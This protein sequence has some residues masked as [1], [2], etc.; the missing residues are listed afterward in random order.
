VGDGSRISFWYD[1][2]CGEVTLKVVFP[3]L[4]GLACAKDAF[5]ASN[6]EILGGFNK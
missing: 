3:A 6:L 5:I 4:Y 2:W 1:K